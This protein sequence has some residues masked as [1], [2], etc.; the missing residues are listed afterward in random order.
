MPLLLENS[1]FRALLDASFP[2]F[3]CP[4]QPPSPAG[5]QQGDSRALPMTV[6]Y[7]TQLLG[8]ASC[9]PA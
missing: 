4:S 8:T 3:P 9:F 5:L 6:G 2:A 7:R 1:A